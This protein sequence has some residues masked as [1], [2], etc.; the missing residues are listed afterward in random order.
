VSIVKQ[1]VQAAALLGGEG[2]A[3]ELISTL[4]VSNDPAVT[5]AAIF[6][7]ADLSPI[8]G[9]FTIKSRVVD[10]F[11]DVLENT[12]KS[13]QSSS[14]NEDILAIGTAV[15]KLINF[16]TGVAQPV[17]KYATT[18]SLKLLSMLA[19]NV[20]ATHPD[21]STYA[22]GAFGIAHSATMRQKWSTFFL[23]SMYDL[24]GVI[25]DMT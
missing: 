15:A 18:R 16:E 22:Q 23:V 7:L 5:H 24:N 10:P 6:A 2:P 21:L 12:C 19:V 3:A 20:S 13:I 4:I 14:P 9:H 8:Q 25:A 11:C 1:C 17:F